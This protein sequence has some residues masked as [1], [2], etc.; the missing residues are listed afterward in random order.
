MTKKMQSSNTL[1]KATCIDLVVCI[2]YCKLEVVLETSFEYRW[3]DERLGYLAVISAS[4]CLK[5]KK[6]ENTLPMLLS[7]CVHADV[8]LAHTCDTPFKVCRPVY[9]VYTDTIDYRYKP[10]DTYAIYSGVF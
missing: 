1:V 6:R 4:F 7:A 9:S 2:A 3:H 5:V 10:R 8:G